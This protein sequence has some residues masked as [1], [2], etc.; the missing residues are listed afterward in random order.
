MIRCLENVK[1]RTAIHALASL[2]LMAGMFFLGTVTPEIIPLSSALICGDG[3]ADLEE[4]CD[5][6]NTE[7]GDTCSRDCLYTFCG[8]GAIERPNADN[9][10]EQCDDGNRISGDGCS[11]QCQFEDCGNGVVQADRG[12]ECDNGLQ[13]SDIQPNACRRSCTRARCGDGVTDDGEDC[14]DGN[15]EESDDCPSSCHLE[16]AVAEVEE[17]QPPPPTMEVEPAVPETISEQP[18]EDMEERT[19]EPA[20]SGEAEVEEATPA[21]AAMEV[22]ETITTI[23]SASPGSEIIPESL[24]DALQSLEAGDLERA[25]SSVEVVLEEEPDVAAAVQVITVAPEVAQTTALSSVRLI[26]EHIACFRQGDKAACNRSLSAALEEEEGMGVARRKKKPVVE[27]GEGREG[28][29]APL[30]AEGALE[31]LLTNAEMTTLLVRTVG[32]ATSAVGATYWDTE[33]ETSSLIERVGDRLAA[34]LAAGGM[35]PVEEV[36]ASLTRAKEIGNISALQQL[37]RDAG[38]RMLTEEEEKIT[39]VQLAEREKELTTTLELASLVKP[40]DVVA[41]E[42]ALANLEIVERMIDPL[43][44]SIRDI[45]AIALKQ[46]FS[47]RL[48]LL[49]TRIASTDTL[50][51]LSTLIAGL[52]SLAFDVG[53]TLS[54]ERQEQ[55]LLQY[56]MHRVSSLLAG[57]A[58]AA[59]ASIAASVL[60]GQ[61]VVIGN[62]S[63][64][65]FTLIS[66]VLVITLP[67]LHRRRDQRA[68]RRERRNVHESSIHP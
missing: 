60:E 55:T 15:N 30:A 5:D 14:D 12:E 26:E 47:E 65:G 4:Q 21:Q 40:E 48:Q 68:M 38:V 13:N 49:S 64:W 56:L 28:A 53:S 42:E 16:H 57:R 23:E 20:D 41:P 46:S 17:E 35:K 18:E 50:E 2:A 3:V 61:T 8:D 6:G 63:L 67:E 29:E 51:E 58:E 1:T 7:D 44:R 19:E 11:P 33:W 27:E 59:D 39:V 10:Q 37:L 22:M 54:A 52:Q 31:E 36:T 62:L 32:K 45:Q 25:L 9:Q 43:E 66:L 34:R 24:S